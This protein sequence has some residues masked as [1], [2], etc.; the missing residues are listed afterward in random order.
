[1]HVVAQLTAKAES[2]VPLRA[3][4]LLHNGRLGTM[5]VLAALAVQPH[6]DEGVRV[7]VKGRG[8]GMG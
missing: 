1:M 5:Q 2:L 7:R 6:L 3:E 8:R 4:R